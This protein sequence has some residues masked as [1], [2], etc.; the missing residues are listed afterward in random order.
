[1]A[2]DRILGGAIRKLWPAE[3]DQF[4]DHLLRLDKAGRRM[5]FAHAVSDGFVADYAARMSANGAIVYGY[6]VEN[7]LH[8]VAELRKIGDTWGQ[9]AEAAF[10]VETAFQEKGIA[11][12]LLGRVI[13]SA[14][15][16]G[17]RHLVMSC[18][19][20]NAKMQAVARHYEAEL[21]FEHGEVIGDIVPDGASPMS[22]FAEAVDDRMGYLM[23]VF[24]L[25]TPATKAV[26]AA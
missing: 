15:N 3:T 5:R 20:D 24:D 10:S 19:A 18:L 6:F 22:V 17:V 4:R 9:E 23:A 7:E 2:N 14:R 21:R 1:M 8:A 16:R 11:T 25:K 13:R 26:N 12:E